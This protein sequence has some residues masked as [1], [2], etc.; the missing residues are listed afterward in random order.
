MEILFSLINGEPHHFTMGTIKQ[1]AKGSAYS[2][3]WPTWKTIKN[4]TWIQD[5]I[6]STPLMHGERGI[7]MKVSMKTVCRHWL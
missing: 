7:I 6:P 3:M 2:M 4:K 1:F 5:Y